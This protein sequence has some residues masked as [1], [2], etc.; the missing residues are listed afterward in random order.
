V[1]GWFALRVVA[2]AD[3]T[4]A[5]K[6]ASLLLLPFAH[7][8]LAIVF[9]AYFI[10]HD[11]MPAG[12][13]ALGLYGGIVASDFALY[14]IG[15]GARR[16]PWL[17][18]YAIDERVHRFS[19]ALKR[20]VFGLVALCRVVP[21][22]VFVAF[23]ACG[24]MRVPFRRFTLASLLISALY[25]PL[26]LY[27][28]I[29][30]GDTLDDYVGL[31]TWP[32]LIGAMAAAGFARK[33]ILAFAGG[34]RLVDGDIA[35]RPTALPGKSRRKVARA[36]R[37]PPFLF[38]A[39]LVLTWL[40]LGLRYRCLT[41]PS[42]ANP[43]IATGGM[44]GES[45]SRYFLDVDAGQ[46]RWIA[47][48]V[49]L[50]RAGSLRCEAKHALRMLADAG[51]DFPVVAKP[52]IGWQGYGVRRIDDA[53]AL[54]HYLWRFPIGARLILQ[55]LVPYDGEAAVLY[56][57]PPG[58]PHGRILSLTFR[59]FPHVI[60]D[61]CSTVRELICA[62]ARLRWKSRLHLGADPSHQALGAGD[63]AGVPARGEMVQIALI[64]NQRAG[65]SYRDA[66]Q[67][68]TPALE[69]RFDAI[70][71]SMGEFHYG[72]FDVRFAGVDAL[73]RGEDFSIIEIN[74]IG[75][76]AIDAWDPLLP[77]REV[78]R[79]L[80]MHQRLLFAIGDGNRTRGFQP[81]PP[82]EFLRHLFRQTRLI[83]HYPPSS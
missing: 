2:N 33:Q 83:R 59:Q 57:R 56:G 19:D 67:C 43:M 74:G 82:A 29:V 69:A 42:A 73:M 1:S 40:G 50:R 3:F 22:I 23:I 79:R 75:G 76:E 46:R 26:A 62:D 20:N 54:A 34:D 10:V 47:D 24:W 60:G 77:V 49:V 38:Y 5:A 4:W 27:L 15:A 13:V 21:G 32:L 64:A 36:E 81:T 11:L 17:S 35:T 18:R 39:P 31:W 66:G 72:R 45:K 16:L 58:E 48:F 41:L 30:F 8:D 12:F 63:L 78:Y 70:A 6:L 28:A 80:L 37:I 65:G 51:V 9:G 61:G 14:G 53:S 71:C 44:W 7:E 68:I 52:D 25:L 55:R